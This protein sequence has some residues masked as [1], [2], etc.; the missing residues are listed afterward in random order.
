MESSTI[1]D[2]LSKIFID[3]VELCI[4]VPVFGTYIHLNEE[5]INM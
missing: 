2:D 4:Q 5:V 3:H 1:T